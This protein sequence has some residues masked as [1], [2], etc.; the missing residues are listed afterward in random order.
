MNQKIILEPSE[1][2]GY[3]QTNKTDLY[4]LMHEIASCVEYGISVYLSINEK[5][6][7]CIIVEADSV[8]IYSEVVSDAIDCETTVR[9]I[10]DE[11]LTNK[12]IEILSDLS[13]KNT[14]NELDKEDIISAREEELDTFIY[15]FV[16]NVIGDEMCLD[17]YDLDDIFDD[18]KEHFLE[19]MARKHKLLIFRPMYLEDEN[20][21]DFYEE[22]PY[23]CMEFEDEENPIYKN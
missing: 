2:W 19:Y 11:Y 1:V 9:K 15:E 13:E 5:N 18:L 7:P 4:S 6:N 8:E 23:E 3:Y 22:Y 17:G 21:K 14:Q 12:A 16:M 20:G 10:Y